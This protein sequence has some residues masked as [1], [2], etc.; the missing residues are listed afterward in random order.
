VPDYRAPLEGTTVDAGISQVGGPLGLFELAPDPGSNVDNTKIPGTAQGPKESNPS[1]AVFTSPPPLPLA[2]GRYRFQFM[3]DEATHSDFE[4]ARELLRHQIPGGDTGAIM[5]LALRRL[6]ADLQRRKFGKRSGRRAEAKAGPGTRTGAGAVRK[7]SAAHKPAKR[8]IPAAVRREVAQR[9]GERCTYRT[10]DGRRCTARDRL[11]FHHHDPFA[12]G[13]AATVDNLS[14]RCRAHHALESKA[15][16]KPGPGP[17]K[18]ISP[19]GGKG[20][21]LVRDG[22]SKRPGNWFRNQSEGCSAPGRLGYSVITIGGAGVGDGSDSIKIRHPSPPPPAPPPAVRTPAAG[23]ESRSIHP[24][25]ATPT[26]PRGSRHRC[27]PP[28]RPG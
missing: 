5:A 6:A 9:D 25:P 12:C 2:P 27:T 26:S 22:A 19:R 8:H 17:G 15:G 23:A 10:P 11:E 28:P 21:G 20:P 4:I 1:R 3:A 24:P 16:P 18:R 14:L 7:R 13:G